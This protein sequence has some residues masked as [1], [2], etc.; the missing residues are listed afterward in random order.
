[1]IGIPQSIEILRHNDQAFSAPFLVTGVIFR[2]FLYGCIRGLIVLGLALKISIVIQGFGCSTT[3]RNLK[4]ILIGTFGLCLVTGRNRR[5]GDH[6]LSV[7]LDPVVDSRY[8][9]HLIRIGQGLFIV[10]LLVI[11]LHEVGLGKNTVLLDVGLPLQSFQIGNRRRVIVFA[12]VDFADP[13]EGLLR[14]LTAGFVRHIFIVRQSFFLLSLSKVQLCQ[15]ESSLHR[16]GAIGKLLHIILV[17]PNRRIGLA[18]KVLLVGGFVSSIIQLAIRNLDKIQVLGPGGIFVHPAHID[19]DE[20]GGGDGLNGFLRIR[21][22]AYDG[23]KF[24]KRLFVSVGIVVHQA[25]A[26]HGLWY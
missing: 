17:A 21:K 25:L 5:P 11:A 4:H 19:I 6:D 2:Q 3:G 14:V 13:G 16:I 26:H 20:L 22:I 23:L 8:S 10:F 15:I 24:R 9:Q 1:M 7:A 18:L 12:D